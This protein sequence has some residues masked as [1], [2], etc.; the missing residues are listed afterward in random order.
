M[1]V[2][3]AASRPTDVRDDE[4]FHVA[5]YLTFRLRY[6]DFWFFRGDGQS[7]TSYCSL[8]VKQN[9]MA[10]LAEEVLCCKAFFDGVCH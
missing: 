4:Q 9:D 3:L 8:L 5:S 7:I 10:T 6:V 1:F 2:L